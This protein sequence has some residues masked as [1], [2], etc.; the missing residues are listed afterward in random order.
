MFLGLDLGT[1]NVKALVVDR[2]GRCRGQSSVP[3]G[4]IALADGGGEQDIDEIW[5]AACRAIRTAIGEIDARQ[6][7]ALGVSSQGGA[8]ELLD[9]QGQPVGPV[10]SW[11]DA[12]G[13]PYDAALTQRWGD[14]FLI[15]HLGR[16]PC[17]VAPG[18][19]Q[20]IRAEQ[21]ER[22]SQ[23]AGVGFVGDVIVGRLT[24]RRAHDA[25]SLSIAMLLNPAL[26]QAD[27]QVL[28]ELQI[29]ERQLPDLLPAATAAG[30]LLASAAA[31]TGLRAGIPVGPA[32][33]DQ[34]AALLGSGAVT[35][36]D[37]SLGTGSAWVLLANSRRLE[38]PVIRG[39]FVCPH[40]ISGLYGQMISMVNGGSALAWAMQL[41][42]QADFSPADVDATLAAVP[43]GSDGLCFWPL[44]A[45]GAAS[46]E[47]VCGGR[48]LGIGF[49]HTGRHLVRAV[50]EGLACE[51]ARYLGL[52]QAGGLNVD[53]LV[54]SGSAAESRVTPHIIADLTGLTV[55]CCT[56]SAASVWGAAVLARA[57]V[58][59]Q[60]ELASLA[61][62]WASDSIAVRPGADREAYRAL[63]TRYLEPFAGKDGV[64]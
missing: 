11:L 54:L 22:W 20:R 42:G 1:S 9:A 36:G 62:A 13:G 2:D 28:A 15:E 47:T 55:G 33:H 49:G 63:L 57:M 5:R 59:P 53:R 38:R 4:R 21:P 32:I 6:V 58:E 26:G 3:V 14:G 51:L 24:G 16:T 50:L 18:Q 44:L 40:P 45:A 46:A 8:L 10:I 17:A 7:E 30:R 56:R 31:E 12:R 37:V 27:P 48:L 43:A 23:A 52:C 39:A 29:A 25:T 35:P 64:P 61:A 19:L 34:Y 41:V 60:A